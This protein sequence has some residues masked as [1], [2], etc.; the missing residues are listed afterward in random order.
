[1]QLNLEMESEPLAGGAGEPSPGTLRWGTLSED[2]RS[3][4]KDL[5]VNLT[6]RIQN[7]VAS[8]WQNED[9]RKEWAKSVLPLIKSSL[10]E[11]VDRQPSAPRSE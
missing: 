2:P 7:A 11:Q 1:M 4:E 5:A 9:K 10:N 3:L 6:N 8:E